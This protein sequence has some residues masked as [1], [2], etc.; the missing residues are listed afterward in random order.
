MT[1]TAPRIAGHMALRVDLSERTFL[2]DAGFGNPTPTGA[3]CDAADHRSADTARVDAAATCS[4]ATG[5][6]DQARWHVGKPLAAV[7]A[8]GCLRRLQRSEPVHRDASG[9]PIRQQRDCRPIR[10]GWDTPRILE[11]AGQPSPAGRHG[12]SRRTLAVDA[13]VLGL[14]VP[15]RYL[16]A[17]AAGEVAGV[18]AKQALKRRSPDSELPHAVVYHLTFPRRPAIGLGARAAHQHRSLT[19]AQAASF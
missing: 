4:F 9:H 3:A 10:A 17:S 14:T 8:R 16:G 18:R 1:P 13:S 19:V 5:A 6:A 2:V 11:W 12:W 15:C 7:F